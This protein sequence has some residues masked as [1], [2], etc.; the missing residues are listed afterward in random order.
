MQNRITENLDY[1]I[2][3]EFGK[4]NLRRVDA[5]EA[6]ADIVMGGP[7]GRSSAGKIGPKDASTYTTF[8][9]VFV[10]THQHISVGTPAGA[11]APTLTVKAGTV[12]GLCSMGDVYLDIPVS[13]TA[14]TDATAAK[15]AIKALTFKAGDKIYVT[16]AGAYTTASASNTLV[17]A[18]IEDRSCAEIADGDIV[19]TDASDN[20]KDAAAS[21]VVMVRI[22]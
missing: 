22:G 2:P 4:T 15:A 19:V 20:K 18:V 17:G 11:L 5:V 6:A 10:T 12:V 14:Q 3:G 7:A 13:V 8:A 21:I 9:G 1:G 16:S